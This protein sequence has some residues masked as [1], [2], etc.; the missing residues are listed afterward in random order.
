MSTGMRWVKWVRTCHL[1]LGASD[2]QSG[3]SAIQQKQTCTR[4]WNSARSV[5]RESDAQL[6]ASRSTSGS[7]SIPSVDFNG[8][9]RSDQ[10]G[11]H[12]RL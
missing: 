4:K 8:D 2:Q 3:K 12:R 11:S 9:E 7:G 10:P 5:H 1:S 6:G